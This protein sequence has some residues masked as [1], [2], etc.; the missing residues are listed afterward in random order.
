VSLTHT[1]SFFFGEKFLWF[2]TGISNIFYLQLVTKLF[3]NNKYLFSK[4]D[5]NNYMTFKLPLALDFYS[6]IIEL[7]ALL[8]LRISSQ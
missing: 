7:D 1:K 4:I 5:L 3:S 8:Y 6:H 2:I